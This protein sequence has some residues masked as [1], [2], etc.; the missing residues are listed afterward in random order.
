MTEKPRKVLKPKE[1]AA[2]IGVDVKTIAKLRT[3]NLIVGHLNYKS[4][5]REFWKYYQDDIEAYV[6]ST[7]SRQKAGRPRRPS[8]DTLEQRLHEYTKQEHFA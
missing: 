5:K 3:A 7:R 6:A 4:P 1:A 8:R 2:L